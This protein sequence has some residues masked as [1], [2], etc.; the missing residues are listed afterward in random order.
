[1]IP[2]TEDIKLKIKM[3]KNEWSM[4]KATP[5]KLPGKQTVCQVCGSPSQFVKFHNGKPYMISGTFRCNGHLEY[6]DG[7]SEKTFAHYPDCVSVTIREIK[8]GI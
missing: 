3:R 7:S 4:N 5:S 6:P 2:V 8:V 1:M